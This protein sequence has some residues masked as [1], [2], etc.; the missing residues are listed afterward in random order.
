MVRKKRYFTLANKGLNPNLPWSLQDV[1]AIENQRMFGFQG[2]TGVGHFENLS[3]EHPEGTPT[4]SSNMTLALGLR[5]NG[6]PPSGNPM[7]SRFGNGSNAGFLIQELSVSRRFGIVMGNCT[8]FASHSLLPGQSCNLV[9]TFSGSNAA[10]Y[11]NGVLVASGT[12]TYLP[13]NTGSNPFIIGSSFNGAVPAVNWNISYFSISPDYAQTP[14]EVSSW[15]QAVRM[16]GPM[17]TISA[18]NFWNARDLQ[19]VGIDKHIISPQWVDR[20]NNLTIAR[21]TGSNI[22]L[23]D[24]SPV[25]PSKW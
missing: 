10:T 11:L 20:I 8:M 6:P 9:I 12:G 5:Y 16:T 19:T 22:N 21:I 7:I 24:F 3:N 13:P 25:Y 2:L 17:A 15:D 18:S 14:Q 4:G 1:R 23:I